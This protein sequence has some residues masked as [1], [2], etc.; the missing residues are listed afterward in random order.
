[1]QATSPMEMFP[2]SSNTPG[3]M[4]LI[5]SKPEREFYGMSLLIAPALLSVS[6]F[7]WN[8]RE[9][10]VTGGSF[11]SMSFV[12]WI[13]SLFALFGL[14][15]KK[16]PRYAAWGLAL[17]MA[18]CVAGINFGF[19]GVYAE[20]FGISHEQYLASFS[21][22][23]ISANLLL[24]ATGPIFPLS[25]FILAIQWLRTRTVPASMAI[26]FGFGALLFPL[27]RIIRI[28]WL[29]H[30]VDLLLLIPMMYIGF[31]FLTQKEPAS[32]LRSSYRTSIY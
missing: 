12:C 17:A 26:L 21:R 10:G 14:L 28:N 5:Y 6:A 13:P 19:A 30:G 31:I 2:V 32:M 29:A 8:G 9:F 24:F 20:V 4:D 15:K 25:L 11:L 22:Y 27:S 23:P 16:M 18:G 1:M 7:L 3:A